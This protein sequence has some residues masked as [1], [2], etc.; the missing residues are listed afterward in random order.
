MLVASAFRKRVAGAF[1]LA[2]DAD[3]PQPGD[4]LWVPEKPPRSTW[5]TVRDVVVLLSQ[6]ATIYLVIDQAT[7]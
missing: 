7:K 5:A 1:L 3:A 4:R 6:V 2:R